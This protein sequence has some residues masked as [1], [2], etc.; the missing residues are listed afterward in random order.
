MAQFVI[1]FYKQKKRIVFHFVAS[2]ASLLYFDLHFDNNVSWSYVEGIERFWEG[3]E[4]GVTIV[5]L[6]KE[7]AGYKSEVNAFGKEPADRGIDESDAGGLVGGEA[8]VVMFCTEGN[9]PLVG[10]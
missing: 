8:R 4:G 9:M 1:S 3:A 6:V 7:I 10:R 5:R 2:F